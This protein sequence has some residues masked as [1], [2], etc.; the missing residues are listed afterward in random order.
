[1][2]TDVLTSLTTQTRLRVEKKL[3]QPWDAT[4]LAVVFALVGFGLVML[5]S[6]SAVMATDKL[7]DPF[8][9]VESQLVK[10]ACGVFMMFVALQVDYRWYKRLIYPI[11]AGAL[12]ML[13]GVLIPGIGSAQ[14]GAQRWFS[15]A[16]FS[17]QPAEVVKI[18]IVMY[19]AYSVAKKGEKMGRFSVGFI[20]HLAVVGL[21][22]CLLMLQPDFG[23]SCILLTMMMV[24]LFVSGAR[25]SYLFLFS[26]L[27]CV[28]AYFA[29]TGSAYRMRRIM[30][31]LDP[32]SYRTDIGYQI[33]ESL[34]AIGSGG[35]TG[36]GLGAGHGKLGYVP[37]LW[38]D[39]IGTIVAEELG[40]VGIVILVL[41]FGV[42]I[43]RGL[44]IAYRC[45]DR[46]GRYLAF[47]LTILFGLQAGAN[48]CVVT[49]LLPTKGLTLPFVSFGGSSMIMALFGVGVLLNISKNA[50][51][52][53][54][55]GRQKRQERK[56][57]RRWK[58]KRRR[59]LNRR[60]DLARKF[61]DA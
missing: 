17:F 49:G 5:Y 29:V 30:A 20:P 54:E 28:G 50:P 43:W 24:M 13:V 59:I 37:E 16:G 52:V 11:L 56:E 6:A 14:N 1:M 58:K 9:L 55:M 25:I 61:D 35:L 18:A 32:W 47:G 39:F 60:D 26:I 44:R 48:L 31:F 41:L 22:V 23:S 7:G 40:L 10:V 12:L 33:S 57:E 34:I 45:D 15:I 19:L 53:W 21:T 4:L 51:D 42:L 2:S 27:G 46:F 3:R 36:V 38:N 8:Y